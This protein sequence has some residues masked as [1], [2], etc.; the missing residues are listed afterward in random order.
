MTTQKEPID[1]LE[2]RTF[3]PIDG[4]DSLEHGADA[5][6]P[7]PEALTA[8]QIIAGAIAAGR[9]VFCLVTKMESPRRTLDD[10]NAK[11]IGALWGPVL[12]KHGIDLAKYI[13]DYGL[14]FTALM[15]TFAIAAGVRKG[16]LAEMDAMDRRQDTD[17]HATEAEQ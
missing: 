14:E 16:V 6:P 13:G 11:A 2:Q 15:G 9:E 5:G 7:E 3:T 4:G 10:A 8:A 12:D 1:A 17:Q